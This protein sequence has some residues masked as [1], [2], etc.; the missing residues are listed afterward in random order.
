[1][2]FSRPRYYGCEEV[3]IF[4]RF[5]SAGGRT[6]H[7]L[8]PASPE[9]GQVYSTFEPIRGLAAAHRP[10]AIHAVPRS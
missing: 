1:M 10:T 9:E 4:S 8:G 3:A 7:F 6:L 2:L 5:P